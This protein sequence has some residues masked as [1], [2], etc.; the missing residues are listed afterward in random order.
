M[1]R[2]E[3]MIRELMDCGYERDQVDWWSD[4]TLEVEIE[5]LTNI[6]GE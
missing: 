5:R 6:E 1:S 3:Y 4:Y 2:R